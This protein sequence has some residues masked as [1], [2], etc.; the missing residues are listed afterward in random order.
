[1]VTKLLEGKIDTNWGVL[2]SEEV[3]D[4]SRNSLNR[5]GLNDLTTLENLEYRELES[6]FKG[7]NILFYNTGYI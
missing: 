1:M 7:K 4:R 2:A 6:S 5:L 3:L